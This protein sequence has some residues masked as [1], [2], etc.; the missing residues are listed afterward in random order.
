METNITFFRL[1]LKT[2]FLLLLGCLLT[3]AV[4]DQG[5]L[6][7]WIDANQART[8]MGEQRTASLPFITL[9]CFCI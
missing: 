6:F 2:S 7:M 5:G 3:K 8:L 9:M 1:S 4:G